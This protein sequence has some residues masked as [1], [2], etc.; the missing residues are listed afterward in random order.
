MRALN[1]PFNQ[2]SA[3]SFILE[4]YNI[5]DPIDDYTAQGVLE[6]G[7]TV[8]VTPV[9][10]EGGMQIQWFVNNLPLDL[11]G[12]T[13]FSIASLSLPV[14]LHSLRVEVV[15][16]TPWVRDEVARESIMKQT[17]TWSL[18]IDE[19]VCTGDVNGDGEVSV[20]DLLTVIDSWGTCGGCSADINEDGNV[21]VTD[22]LIIVD[23]WG[24]CP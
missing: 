23:A 18:Q 21:N 11:D 13:S 10:I 2:P 22:L 3:E 9:A 4:M 12:V 16:P 6:V 14:G 7:D 19:V 17:V 8:F 24:A 5:V 20:S 1:R 15:D